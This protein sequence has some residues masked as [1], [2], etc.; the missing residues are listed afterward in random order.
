MAISHAWIQERI[1]A[2]QAGDISAFGDVV[3]HLHGVIRGYL[4]M[5]GA[6]ASEEE[7]L[8]QRTFIEAFQKLADFDPGRPFL[9]WLR[10]IAR[11]ALLRWFERR[12][13]EGRHQGDRVRR[14]LA[15]QAHVGDEADAADAR[16]DAEHLKACLERLKPE[17]VSLIRDR[18][19]ADL[20]AP[21]IAVR[22]GCTPESIRMALSRARASL[23]RCIEARLGLGERPPEGDA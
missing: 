1:L 11:Y 14:F 8:A 7:E 17:A 5:H 19:Y 22:D 3:E 15:E 23:R 10:G 13:I 18:Y 20:D 4:A 21:A 6:P 16:F 12:E 9:P 2:A